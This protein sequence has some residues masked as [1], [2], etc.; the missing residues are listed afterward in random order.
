MQPKFY[1]S[2]QRCSFVSFRDKKFKNPLLR[3]S[4][5]FFR[6]RGANLS[7]TTLTQLLS[8]Q[9]IPY[10]SKSEHLYL[11]VF[12]GWI[13]H[14]RRKDMRRR[15][16]AHVKKWSRRKWEEKLNSFL[17]EVILQFSHKFGLART[18]KAEFEPT[19]QTHTGKIF[20]YPHIWFS[21]E[22]L[23][24]C[25]RIGESKSRC[26]WKWKQE[27]VSLCGYASRTWLYNL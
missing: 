7:R 25:V 5:E 24:Q 6:T 11:K 23:V 16:S 14:E 27:R 2:K 15:F 22:V 3:K 10:H 1:F 18:C 12:W 13:Y 26:S 9:L 20:I 21:F 19:W 4:G 17:Y 8:V